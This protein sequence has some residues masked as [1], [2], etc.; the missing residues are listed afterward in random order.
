MTFDNLTARER[1][2]AA[3]LALGQT[4]KEI[5]LQLDVSTKTVDTHR[6]NLIKKLAVRNNVE[7]ARKAIRDGFVSVH[8]E[9]TP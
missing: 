2:V 3:A 1:Q 4:C 7:L 6:F 8:D 9:V 5:A